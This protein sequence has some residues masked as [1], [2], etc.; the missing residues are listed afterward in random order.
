MMDFWD[1][2]NVFINAGSFYT[3]HCTLQCILFVVEVNFHSHQTYFCSSNTLYLYVEGIL[4][5]ILADLLDTGYAN[6]GPPCFSHSPT[7]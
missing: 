1:V 3:S 5:C 2:D 7:R 6:H 4:V